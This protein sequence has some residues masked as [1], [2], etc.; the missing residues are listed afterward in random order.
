[1]ARRPSP[2]RLTIASAANLTTI[3]TGATVE[4]SGPNS[5]FTN[6]AALTT[7]QGRFYLLDGQSFT[8]AGNLTNSGRLTLSPGSVLAV[9]GNFTQKSAGGLVLE[10]G[11]TNASPTIGALTA[12]G[13]I[14]IAGGLTVT[15]TVTPAIGTVFTVV[16]NQETSGFSGLFTDLPQGS[17]ISVNG[18]VFSISYV[19][20]S[21]S[22]SVTL[23]RTA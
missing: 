3:G 21:K 22:N 17:T 7:N 10:M 11:G 23:T 18:M 9:S 19:G 14:N 12:T 13:T 5:T 2:R 8:T 15:G 4:L 6:L 20:G 1:M 16:S